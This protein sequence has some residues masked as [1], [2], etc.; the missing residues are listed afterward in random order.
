[1]TQFVQGMVREEEEELLEQIHHEID[2]L[3][4]SPM[5]HYNIYSNDDLKLFALRFLLAN[6]S[7]AF[8]ETE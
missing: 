6:L 1:M 2:V 3:G 7:E 5:V 4:L 8:E